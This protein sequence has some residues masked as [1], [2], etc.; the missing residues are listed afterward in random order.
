MKGKRVGWPPH[1]DHKATIIISC[2]STGWPLQCL[3]YCVLMCPP[4]ASF[5]SQRVLKK[6]LGLRIGGRSRGKTHS[7]FPRSS[8]VFQG[9]VPFCC[10]FSVMSPTT[11]ASPALLSHPTSILA[12]NVFLA[13]VS[14]P[15]HFLLIFFFTQCYNLCSRHPR[16]S[17]LIFEISKTLRGDKVTL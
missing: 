16:V 8:W 5:L 10:G 3:C 7:D 6:T 4:D 1:S 12:S 15:F 11:P 13:D 2:T 14:D 9:T 17:C